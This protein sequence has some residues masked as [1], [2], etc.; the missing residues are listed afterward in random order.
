[1]KEG[2]KVRVRVRFTEPVL[3][4]APK[5]PETYADYIASK[6]AKN[7]ELTDDERERLHQEEV[8]NAYNDVDAV[9]E[10][11]WTGFQQDEEGFYVYNY[12]VRGFLKTAI[13]SLQE[14]GD[15]TKI[16]AYKTK[17][18]RFV[19][20]SPR[21]LRFHINGDEPMVIERPLRAMTAK[22]PRVSL[23]RSDALPAGTELEFS[24][25]LLKNKGITMD[26]VREAL[27][28]GRYEG[29][30]QWRSGGYGT[31]EVVSFDAA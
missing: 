3:G 9:E 13:A 24:I 23:A 25:E 8:A 4:T 6:V 29:M 18:D 5:N 31:L 15:F 2:Q 16:P 14:T 30:G 22:G 11:G 1:M 17:I 7:K 21:K 27:E 19:H 20:V 12:W 26:H 28:W 10:R